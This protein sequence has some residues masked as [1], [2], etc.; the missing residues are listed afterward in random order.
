[1]LAGAGARGI[2]RSRQP[3]ASPSM[4]G[5]IGKATAVP[6]KRDELIAILLEG[7]AGMPGCLSYVVAKDTTDE[8][9]IWKYAVR[10]VMSRYPSCS[11]SDVAPAQ[12]FSYRLSL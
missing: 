11:H 5:L 7:T 10:W 12:V 3:G 1:M 4:Y 8:N 6:G 9:A 2:A